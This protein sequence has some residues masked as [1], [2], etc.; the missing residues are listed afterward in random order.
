MSREDDTTQIP[1]LI[2]DPNTR[3]QYKKGRFFGKGGFAKCYEIINPNNNQAYAGKIV[4]KKLM[5]KQ[6]QK[7]KMTQ[8]IQ[9]HQSLNHKNVVGFYNFFEDSMNIYIVLELCRKRSMMELHKRRKA[10]SEPETRFYMKQIL[11]GVNYLHY[12]KIIHR[13][14]KLGNLFLND[15][16]QV[17]I[18]DFGLAAKIEYDGERKKTLCGT[19]NYIAPEILNKKGHSFEVDIWSIGCIMYTL[20]MGRPP[21]ETSSL[22]E[23]YSR[24]KKCDYKISSAIS[25]PSK[26]MIKLML[27]A[28]PKNRPKVNELAQHEFMLGYCPPSLPVSC[29]TMAPRFDKM[30]TP[31]YAGARKPLLELNQGDAAMAVTPQKPLHDSIAAGLAVQKAHAFDAKESFATLKSMLLKVLKT[32]PARNQKYLDE[33]SDPNAQPMIWVSKWVD[34]SDKYGFGYQLS[35]E[36]VG[37]MFNDT[38]KL[39]MLPNGVTV[40]YIDRNGEETYMTVD[41]YPK[42]LDKKIKL[43]SYF[44]RYMREHLIKTGASVVKESDSL[45]R[46]PHLHQWCRSTSGV[47]MQLNNGTVQMNFGDHTKIIMCPLMSAITYID[48]DKSFRTFKFSSI[49]KNGCSMGLYEKMRYAYDKIS[50]LIDSDNPYEK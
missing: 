42:P 15:E 6:N 36:G 19:P 13:D 27:Q 29:L 38:T 28:E 41:N 14:L 9:I 47:L 22:K 46:T 2:Y 17:K 44:N 49:E 21:F 1:D 34:Y 33:M 4:P 8:E 18:G 45:S 16:L 32:K 20:L 43:L 5:V 12:Q 24:I 35:D 10:I 50:V 30:E 25:A 3:T 40:H 48:E 23:T 7:E 11:S 39:I 26:H 37:V 31:G